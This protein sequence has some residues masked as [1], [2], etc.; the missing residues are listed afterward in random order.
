[1]KRI[2]S[3]AL[4]TLLLLAVAAGCTKQ[5][6]DNSAKTLT[7]QERTDLYKKALEGAL[8]DDVGTGQP[9]AVTG[10]EISPFVFETLG[11]SE[12]DLSAFA[13][14]LSLMNVRAYAVAAIY[15]AE[16]KSDMVME[17]LKGFIDRQKQSFEYYLADQYEIAKNAK[18]EKLDDGT[19][20]LVMCAGQDKIFTSIK[21]AI[22]EG[23]K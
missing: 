18:I 22:N 17:S 8:T 6:D 4:S 2:I 5:G 3:L 9:P 14:D 7:T 13:I 12:K 11:V 15:P 23:N 16:G 20:L 21:A 19:I 1:M 10:D